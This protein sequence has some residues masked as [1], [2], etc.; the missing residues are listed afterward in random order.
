MIKRPLNKQ[1]A[2][3]VLEGRKITTIRKTP[4]PLHTPIMLF[5]WLDKP[6]R[7]KQVDVCPVE[8]QSE[9]V[10]FIDHSK[11]GKIQ[12]ITSVSPFILFGMTLYQTEGFPSQ[13]AM[14]DWFRNATKPETTTAM[15]IM[16]FSR[17]TL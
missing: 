7:S 4:W 12:Y 11:Y 10:I 3:A 9:S 16:R 6:Y 17:I 14:D 15:H 5:H 13:D 1:F 2:A 8:A